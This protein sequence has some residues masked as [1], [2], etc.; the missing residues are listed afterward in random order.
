MK[1]IVKDAGWGGNDYPGEVNLEVCTDEGETLC[2]LHVSEDVI[3]RAGGYDVRLTTYTKNVRK[4]A[5]LRMV[6]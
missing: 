3:S 1:V 6:E 4:P 5:A 2:T